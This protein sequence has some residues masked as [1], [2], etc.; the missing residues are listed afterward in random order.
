MK[1]LKQL[2]TYMGWIWLRYKQLLQLKVSFF[3]IGT[4]W[5]SFGRDV[6]L[7]A[8]GMFYLSYFDN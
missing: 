7:R 8:G 2:K 1:L 4:N 3:L 6:N 5:I